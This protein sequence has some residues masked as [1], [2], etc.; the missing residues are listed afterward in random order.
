MGTPELA[1]RVLEALLR[2]PDRVVGVVTQPDR[3]VGRGYDLKASPV[4]ELALQAGLPILQPERIKGERGKAFREEL[5]RLKPELIVVAAFGK[6]LPKEVLEMPAMGCVNVHASLLPRWRGASPINWAIAAGDTETGVSIMMMDEGLDTGP[7][8]LERRVPIAPG[9]TGGSLHDKLASLGAQ[10]LMEALDLVREGRAQ[11]KAQDDSGATYAPMLSREDARLDFERPADELE[12]RVRAFQPWP[13]AF[14]RLQGRLLKVRRAK[15]L[16]GGHETGVTEKDRTE[17]GVIVS[18][19]AEGVDVACGQGLLR[20][21]EVQPEGKR[22]MDAGAFV[23][24]R[25]GLVRLRLD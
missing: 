3:P 16:P 11:P 23:A 21:L 7:V 14:T 1:A 6:I 4:K 10:A 17:P 15:A 22:P 8:I 24:G 13:G 20:L 25:Q 18:A 5:A 19:S 2:G 9:E 12:R